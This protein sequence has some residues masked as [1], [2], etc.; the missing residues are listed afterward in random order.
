MC[1]RPSPLRF[2]CGS[3]SVFGLMTPGGQNHV[4]VQLIRTSV[5]EQA[6]RAKPGLLDTILLGLGSSANDPGVVGKLKS[7]TFVR[8]QLAFTYQYDLDGNLSRHIRPD[9]SL[10]DYTYNARNL[11]SKLDAD[12]PPPVASYTYNGRKT[13]VHDFYQNPC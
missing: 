4:V 1:V 10:I 6:L 8:I 2:D 12:T 9:G 3:I 13:Q 11:L 7:M 5:P